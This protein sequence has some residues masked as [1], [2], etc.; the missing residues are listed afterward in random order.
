[1]DRGLRLIDHHTRSAHAALHYEDASVALLRAA[2]TAN[3]LAL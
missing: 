2:E 1:M 3:K